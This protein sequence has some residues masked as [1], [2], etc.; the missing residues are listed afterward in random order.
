MQQES[1]D[2]PLG[3]AIEA[4]VG[5]PS[6]SAKYV[7]ALQNLFR[8]L[9][10]EDDGKGDEEA[11]LPAIFT[12]PQ[13]QVMRLLAEW[14]TGRDA[15]YELEYVKSVIFAYAL[16][17]DD[18]E[19]V[20]SQEG[21]QAL[22]E[23]LVPEADLELL[24]SIGNRIDNDDCW[25]RDLVS[26]KLSEREDE[27]DAISD[28]STYHSEL[29]TLF[30]LELGDRGITEPHLRLEFIKSAS[31][32]A[33][34]ERIGYA[35]LENIRIGQESDEQDEMIDV[36][37]SPILKL[38]DYRQG[39]PVTFDPCHWL[40]LERPSGVVAAKLDGLPH[41]VWDIEKRK[42]VQMDSLLPG[43]KYSI[44]SHTWGRWRE[45]AGIRVNGV[46]WLV[47]VIS[48]YDVRDIPQMISDA[49]FN[50]PYVWMDLLCI[51]QEME[52]QWQSEICKQELP[53]QAEI[54]RNASTAVVWL[55]DVDS[56]TGMESAV[57]SLSF[58]Y[59]S[60]A[61]MPGYERSVDIGLAQKAI[62]KE[63]QESTGLWIT[64]STDGRDVKASPAGWFT[65]LWT[66]QECIIRPD[67]VL[68]DR[69][70]RPLVAGQRFL[71][72][73]NSLTA[74]VIQCAGLQMDDIARGPAE[75]DR[76][77]TVARIA[78]L[79]YANQLTPLLVGRSRS[80]TSSR[81]PAI[82]SVIGA[83]E[84]FKG[85]T[86]QQFQTPRQ[87]EDMVCGLY[88]LEFV[89]EVREKVGPSFF[90]CQTEIATSR[91]AVSGASGEPVLQTLKGTMLPFM[92]IPEAQSH[93]GSYVKMTVKGLPGHPSVSSWE[94]L[95]DGRVH[96]TEVAIMASNAGTE[97]FKLRPLR[98]MI[99]C[100]DPRDNKKTMAEF[101]ED[102]VLQDWVA[103]F[104]GEAYALCV[105]TSGT[106]VYGTIIH[107]LES[108]MSFVRA[109]TF[110]TLDTL[111]M[112]SIQTPPT[113]G[114]D[115]YVV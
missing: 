4:V 58:Q 99:L 18:G 1:V 90:M 85:Q 20:E 54:F 22:L 34:A 89:C 108:T 17:F 81:A 67:M 91:Q 3:L 13:H 109:G 63:A 84:W 114:V 31:V 83:T 100:N 10:F 14:W 82:M 49:G 6:T 70:W 57:A 76:L 111:E 24:Q 28:V 30:L 103:M 33:A 39:I 5:G 106:M 61:S 104:G 9:R 79:Y 36:G 66:L 60:R 78:N 44:I 68:L 35:C 96:L 110:E 53:R 115:W 52:V 88:P 93:L 113:T 42:T 97:S 2:G 59:L 23:D 101:R 46:P 41:Y 29:Y 21:S 25:I 45:E 19:D 65:S 87:V 15:D 62:E 26:Q 27:T 112:L 64:D 43:A 7:R 75:I 55:A 94:I 107:R 11:K 69:R 74:L 71:L 16:C 72:D 77:W 56:W 50:E 95:G 47:P 86:L 51:P 37:R 80:S 105:A 73:L 40:K 32:V 12:P 8:V 92:P 38:R 98:C 102:F 48:R